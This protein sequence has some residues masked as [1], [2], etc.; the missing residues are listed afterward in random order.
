MN[1][2]KRQR[3]AVTLVDRDVCVVAG[4]GSGKTTVL[5]ERFAHLILR[6]RAPV[7]RLRAVDRLLA[8]TFTEK[9]ATEMRERVARRFLAEG[10]PDLRRA[11]ET[12]WVSTFHSFCARLLKENAVE[13][14]VD[15]SFQV[16]AE[17]DLG[18]GR[19]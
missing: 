4:A 19:I 17:G 16:L 18:L 6:H 8:L 11:V 7:D 1:L 2:T 10:R 3:D 5:A 14:G 12:A 15:P 9:A 13:A